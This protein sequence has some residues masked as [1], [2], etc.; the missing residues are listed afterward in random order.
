MEMDGMGSLWVGE[1]GGFAF[2]QLI[3]EE[4]GK[5]DQIE[6]WEC[7]LKCFCAGSFIYECFEGQ[8]GCWE[9]DFF[10]GHRIIL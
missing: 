1:G 3:N 4:R 5:R 2:A 9:M 7:E 8:N 6:F 10:V